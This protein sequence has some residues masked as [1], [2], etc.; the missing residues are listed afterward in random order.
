MTLTPEATL[1]IV[2][3][4]ILLVAYAI[5][6]PSLREPTMSRI[7]GIDMVFS[8]L[9]LMIAGYL[10]WE[11]GIRFTMILFSVNWFWFSLVTMLLMEMPLFYWFCR[12]RGL[13]NL[14][15]DDR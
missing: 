10:F 9:S 8:G 7:A 12:D 1:L 6:Y 13:D 15:M 2:N 14:D 11:T 4:V 5:V 3:A